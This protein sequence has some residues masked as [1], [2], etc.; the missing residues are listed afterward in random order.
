MKQSLLIF[1]LFACLSGW[2]SCTKDTAI[3]PPPPPVCDYTHVSYVASVAPIIQNHCNNQSGCH[4]GSLGLGAAAN[5][6]TIYVNVKNEVATDSPG[7]N[8][9]LCRIQTTNCGG[10]QMPKG[11]RPLQPALIDTIKLWKAGG[12]CN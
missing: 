4:N 6:L 1:F 3:A 7:I 2:Y 12:Y 8:S 11:L 9:I 10:D 5:D